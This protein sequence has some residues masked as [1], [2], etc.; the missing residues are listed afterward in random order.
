[1]TMGE[2][3]RSF[4]SLSRRVWLMWTGWV[5]RRETGES[6]ALLRIAVGTVVFGAVLSVVMHDLVD[7]LWVD[8]RYGG[9]RNVTNIHFLVRWLGGPTPDAIWTLVG[10]SLVSTAL[11]VLGFGGRVTT[12]IAQQSFLAL[13]RLNLD[14]HGAYD[15]LISNAMWFLV[16]A[17]TTRTW[18]IDC[19]LRHRR[20]TSDETVLAFPRAL[21]ILQLMLL[22]GTTGI[23]KVSAYWT[24]IHGYSALYF[25]LQQP[26]WHAFDMRWLA[27]P[28]VHWMT[29]V[30][31]AV[32]WFWEVSTPFFLGMHYLARSRLSLDNR[33][34]RFFT[35]IDVRVYWAG[36]GLMMHLGIIFLMNVGPFS[37]VSLA[38]YLAL[39]RPDEVRRL[40]ARVRSRSAAKPK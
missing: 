7:V 17:D 36:L 13:Y 33:L 38:M 32:S 14:A 31:T 20:F 5:T 24:P 30:G 40:A 6:L 12:L 8:D 21:F 27:S 19:W 34:Y 29:R 18:S 22:Y 3:F 9:I 15:T 2:R 11:M 39:L 28:W 37:Y 10:I 4:A 23:Q 26:S 35:R 1:M 16:L 25:I